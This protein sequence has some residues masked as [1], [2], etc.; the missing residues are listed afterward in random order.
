[1]STALKIVPERVA[2]LD[3]SE[4]AGALSGLADAIEERREQWVTAIV[5]ELGRIRFE[6]EGEVALAL[7]RLRAYGEL[8]GPL[9]E[10]RPQGGVAVVFPSNAALSNP[11]GALGTAW[12]AGNRVVGRFPS[13]SRRW[14]A[15]LE[16]LFRDH[17]PGLTFDH[18]PGPEFLD[19]TLAGAEI[20][21][22]MV[23]GDDDWALPYRQKVE[24]GRKKLIFEG[25]GKDPFLVLRGCDLE[26]AARDAVRG[27]F[28][29][30]G[31]ACTS[32]ERFYVHET[33]LG[34]FTEAVVERTHS[35]VIGDP[36]DPRVRMGPILARHVAER[37]RRQLADAVAKG[38]RVLAGGRW[39]DTR[40]SDGRPAVLIEP[41]VLA[42]CHGE[43]ALFQEETFG[44][45]LPI[46]VVGSDEEAL[47]LAAASP[48]GLA[49]SLYGGTRAHLDELA[50]SHGL[51]FHNEI[52][53]DYFGRIP[54]PP[55]GG[56]KR[57]GWVWAWEDGR[58]IER[59][60]PRITYRE[61]SRPLAA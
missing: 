18:R 48:Y 22:V 42:G 1:M 35:L 61:L 19:A 36:Y 3:L 5:Q 26:Q 14:A 6:A 57:S 8:V 15:R 52:W 9:G 46:Q 13:A 59:D 56:R 32:P 53:L 51:V 58:F 60:G 34:E 29:N 27:A 50:K 4:R 2:D 7:R 44:P 54:H 55:Y 24:A 12:L 31:Q 39:S 20:D 47:R 40:L 49:A 43:M 33:L 38:A 21:V 28:S 37:V 16:P 17:L 30:A 45:L 23:F 10:R 25:P 11:V 41:T